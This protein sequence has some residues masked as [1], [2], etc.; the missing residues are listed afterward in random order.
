MEKKHS[1]YSTIII[2]IIGL[3]VSSHCLVVINCNHMS[4]SISAVHNKDK[5]L[6][7]CAALRVCTLVLTLVFK[8]EQFYYLPP[9][10][11][12]AF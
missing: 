4:L 3:K 5:M 9:W 11:S 10:P 6:I 7:Q 12:E 2:N 8:N 1:Y